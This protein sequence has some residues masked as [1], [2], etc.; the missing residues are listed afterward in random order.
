LIGSKLPK[1]VKR[2]RPQET[3]LVET[4]QQ[5]EQPVDKEMIVT[6]TDQSSETVEAR[7]EE[8]IDHPQSE[9]AS[10]SMSES[11]EE[12]PPHSPPETEAEID[13]EESDD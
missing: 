7:V 6:E 10:S 3:E 9:P 12:E 5:S 1:R 13:E 2:K 8:A 11:E 4:S